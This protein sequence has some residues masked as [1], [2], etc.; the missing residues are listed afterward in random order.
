[1]VAECRYFAI[2][3]GEKMNYKQFFKSFRIILLLV[4]IL[5]A[6]VAISPN[7]WADGVAVRS[8]TRNSSAADAGIPNP[9]PEVS[10]RGRERILFINNQ[11]VE[12]LVDFFDMTTGLEPNVTFL[13]ALILLYLLWKLSSGLKEKN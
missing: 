12:T 5:L 9:D 1:M 7:P 6:V 3:H 4:F 13:E 11:P 8:V 2:V 10:P